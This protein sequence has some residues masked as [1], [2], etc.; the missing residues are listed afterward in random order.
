MKIEIHSCRNDL[1]N[2]FFYSSLKFL[3]QL[4]GKH[5]FSV[6]YPL[7]ISEDKVTSICTNYAMSGNIKILSDA[8]C[9]ELSNSEPSFFSLVF[10]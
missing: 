4:C 7:L 2:A 5:L 9:Q 10:L 3:I 1:K 8:E 6:A